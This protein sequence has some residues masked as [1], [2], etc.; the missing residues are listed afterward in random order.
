M[1]ALD[2][3]WQLGGKQPLGLIGSSFGGWAAAA[4]AERH[5]GRVHRLLLLCPVSWEVAKW[6][7]RGKKLVREVSKSAVRECSAVAQS[8][9]LADRWEGIVGGSKPMTD[10]KRQ[11]SR[12]FLL[13]SSGLPVSI[14]WS[15]A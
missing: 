13:P 9:G 15:F 11:G 8:F 1:R 5:P 2:E 4:Y 14:P 6:A 12:T 3:C 7:V 10:W